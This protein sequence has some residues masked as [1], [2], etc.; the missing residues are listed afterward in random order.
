MNQGMMLAEVNMVIAAI[1][2]I[3]NLAKN[4]GTYDWELAMPAGNEI[5]GG[6]RVAQRQ[7]SHLS[8]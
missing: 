7:R 1:D 4:D 6:E 5:T 3:L 8:H 2:R